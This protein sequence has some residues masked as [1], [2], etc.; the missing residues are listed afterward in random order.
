MESGNQNRVLPA[1]GDLE[2]SLPVRSTHFCGAQSP[3][4][5]R[6][7][8]LV[9]LVA[10]IVDRR[11]LRTQIVPGPSICSLLPASSRIKAGRFLTMNCASMVL[12]GCAEIAYPA[13]FIAAAA[14]EDFP[15]DLGLFRPVL[16]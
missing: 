2:G 12:S 5:I 1:V 8:S 7:P 4:A 14:A 15:E 6:R 10:A 9:G 3:A 16:A 13:A 11:G